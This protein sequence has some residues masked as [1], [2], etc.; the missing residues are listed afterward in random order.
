VEYAVPSKPLP[1]A[2][3]LTLPTFGEVV[4]YVN[5]VVE[6]GSEGTVWM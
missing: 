6:I 2:E 4:E 1:E 3:L 5:E